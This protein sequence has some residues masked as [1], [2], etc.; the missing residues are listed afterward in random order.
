MVAETRILAA[1][2]PNHA[3]AQAAV[4]ELR[5]A[6]FAEEAI[7]ILYTDAGHLIT[8]GLVD[9]AVWGG[10]IGGLV[11]L[12]FPP[13]GL[14]IVAGPIVGALTSGASLAAVGAITVGALEGVIVGL[15]SLG[16]P[17]DVATRLGQHL[18]KGDAL[19]IAHA[20][21]PTAAARAQAI[22]ERHNPRPES[23]PET[24]GIVSA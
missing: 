10:V 6:G 15:V 1:A 23:A 16:M 5:E 22:L 8:A 13:A 2:Y 18:H 21:D 9:G 20:A 11:G 3:D 7:S 19:V 12:L 4:A 14:L 24:G 17:H